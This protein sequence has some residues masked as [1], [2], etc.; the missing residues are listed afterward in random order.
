MS[1][2]S[3]NDPDGPLIIPAEYYDIYQSQTFTGD[4]DIQGD[5]PDD[6]VPDDGD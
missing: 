6:T 5:E 4:E 3:Y 2:N 1:G